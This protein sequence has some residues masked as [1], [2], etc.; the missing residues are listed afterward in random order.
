MRVVVGVTVWG[1]LVP[2]EAVAS[3]TT[4]AEWVGHTWQLHVG[5]RLWRSIRLHV[6]EGGGVNTRV[7]CTVLC[8]REATVTAVRTTCGAGNC[9]RWQCESVGTTVGCRSTFR[10]AERMLRPRLRRRRGC[11]A[12]R[13][14]RQRPYFRFRGRDRHAAIRCPA[15]R[16]LFY[17]VSQHLMMHT[18]QHLVT[19]PLVICKDKRVHR[20][21]F[22]SDR[23]ICAL[24]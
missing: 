10:P 14:V 1:L 13:C 22:K 16:F 11:L 21:Y 6:G 4:A 18:L 7:L 24:V 12:C 9:R 23:A 15:L 8:S 20:S 5:R 19:L 17:P 2:W 3:P